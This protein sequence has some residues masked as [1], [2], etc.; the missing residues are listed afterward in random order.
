MSENWKTPPQDDGQTSAWTTANTAS[1]EGSFTEVKTTSWFERLKGAFIG[2]LIGLIL[3]PGSAW[4]L[5][6]NEGR[7]VQTAR[8][9]TE[10]ASA[11]VAA[12]PARIDPALE[13]RLVYL[14][15]PLSVA[16]PLR[17]PEFGVQ[18]DR[19]L[20]LVRSV[21]MYQ[22]RE[23]QRSE[24]RSQLGGGQETVTTYSYTRGWSATQIESSRFRQ[25]DG[26]HNPPMRFVARST[27]APEA[28]LGARRLSA[29]QIA[30]LGEAR[31]LPLDPQAFAPP[32]G[33]KVIDGT[34]HIGRDPQNPQIGD[35]RIR[36]AVAPAETASLVAAQRG[37]GFA[38]Y[39][40][41]AGDRVMMLRADIVPASEMFEQAQATNSIMT[42]VLRVV[43]AIAMF[44][45]FSMIMRPLSVLAS[46][47]PAIGAIIAVGTGLVA[48]ILT[49]AIAPVIIAIAWIF[50]RPLLGI[51]VLV[52]G[53]AAA[54]GLVWRARQ[55]PAALRARA[56]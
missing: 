9:L 50:Y 29:E 34:L 10:G 22:W 24:T 52:I 55:R 11:T 8:S 19:A 37:D 18:V 6:W 5:F 15:G 21:E 23:E 7:A 32:P 41:R 26:R 12:D 3:V 31:P 25:P 27:V 42:W 43:G 40:T 45:G 14:A 20:R 33:A 51:A 28:R 13:G 56:G 47:I 39:Q 48:A 44:I 1:H 2:L 54:A 30:T 16:A 46:V 17:D 4:M 38:P 53:L 35:M 36:F 49:L